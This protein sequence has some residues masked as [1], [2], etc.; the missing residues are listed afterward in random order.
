MVAF[1]VKFGEEQVK[2]KPEEVSSEVLKYLKEIASEYL[3]SPITKAV[4]TIPAYFSNAQRTATRKAAKLA[5]LSVV[6][7]VTEPVAGALHYV[8][9]KNIQGKLLV[10]DFGGGTLDVS[11]IEANGNEFDVV[12]VSGDTTLGGRNIDRVLLHFFNKAEH[13]DQDSPKYIRR[14]RRLEEQCISLK[15]QLSVTERFTKILDCYN[16]EED[17][18]LTLDR[19]TFEQ[20]NNYIFERITSIVQFSLRDVKCST[21]EINKVILVGGSTRIPKIRNSLEQLFGK[22]KICTDLNPDEAVAAGAAISAAL[23]SNNLENTNQFKVTEVTPLSLGWAEFGTLMVFSIKRNMKLPTTVIS[24]ASTVHDFQESAKFTVYEGERKDT[25]FNNRLGE[26]CISD[27]PKKPA[28]EVTFQIVFNLDEDGIL[29]VTANETTTGKSN[30][31]VVTMSEF[32][33]SE[34]QISYHLEQAEREK[35]ADNLHELFVRMAHC[36]IFTKNDDL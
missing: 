25:S 28:G 8:R 6:K 12:G 15:E 3:N 21:E 32:R 34:T 11:I 5:G 30:Q 14:I 20:L 16:G 31:L 17:L 10:V 13:T 23:L 4:I 27:L 29:T 36:S 18:N 9:D 7:F 19:S 2:I 1:K 33:L 26:F 35:K 24:E 22:D